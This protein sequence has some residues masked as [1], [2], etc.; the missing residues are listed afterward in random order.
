MAAAALL[1][2]LAATTPARA[3]DPG[4]EWYERGRLALAQGE[5]WRARGHFE[6]A[7]REGYPDNP[8]YR[9]LADAWM[10]LDHRLFEAREALE[11]AVRADPEDVDSWYR[12][13]DVNLKLDGGDADGRSRLAFHQVFR[14]DPF[15]RDAWERWG[16]LYLDPVDLTAVAETF[17]RH[18]ET[19]YDPRVA[20]RRIEVLHD[21]GEH[22]AA[23]SEIE[24]FRRIV[25]DEAHLS[26][27]S[28][29][30]GVV[31]AAREQPLEG[32][33]YYFNGL[34]FA[35]TPGDLDP[36]FED[37][38]PLLDP[39]A[40]GTWTEWDLERRRQFLRGWW[41]ARD[42]LPF[43]DLNER[44]AEQQRRIRV[45][46]DAFRWKKPI[47]KEKLVEQGGTDAGMPAVA[48]RLDGRPL[49][50]RGAFYLRH[51]DPDD[52]ADPG[53]D[54]CGFW[55]YDREEIP[56]DR[57]IA[58]NF[59]R[60]GA[61]LGNDCNFV[62]VPSTPKGLQHFSPGVGGLDPFQRA[63]VQEATTRDLAVGLS[64]DS[65]PVP[66]DDPIPLDVEPSNFSYFRDGTDVVIY[67]AVPLPEIEIEE[68]HSRYRK[69]LV[70]YD[71][72]WNEI[73]RS[74]EEMDAVLARVPTPAGEREEWYLVD[75]FRVRTAPGEYRFALQVDDLLGD[76]VGVRKGVLRVRRFAPT[77]LDLSDP[78][79]S[80]RVLEGGRAPRFER[81]GRT[82]IPLPG[83]RFV[84]GGPLWLYYEVY[85]LQPDSDRRLRFRIEYTIRADRLDRGAVERL[86]GALSGLV[87]IR[88]DRGATT[89]SFEREAPHPG[90]GV[91]PEDLSFD[92]S[93][94]PAGEYALDVTVI[95]H[96]FYDRRA[97]R[98]T[99]FTIVD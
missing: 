59:A 74:A 38:A 89:L 30:A 87:G 31:L 35:R 39:A 10:A 57:S 99:T 54:E 68:G 29:F 41:N 16:R 1:G 17:G 70:I 13:A 82:I 47:T 23:W 94:L 51:G 63:R 61:F 60:G 93:G 42:P 27:L 11:G 66:I 34:A 85:N 55:L 18:L 20:L 9:A 80:T 58:M 40:R 88:E 25:K 72:E 26:R 8:G 69:G 43:S 14:L 36:Y 6:R 95:D 83:K 81:Y 48:I 79:V 5:A 46:R 50:D 2:A 7:L 78:L 75:L 32:A 65:W 44:W 96:V 15:H 24:R 67:F 4:T 45:A 76:G 84:R 73:T 53:I 33:S 77:G 71:T 3:Q 98:S 52:R 64:T 49:D 86:F 90:R 12:L 19:A 91:W 21:A 92:T 28:Y 37:V 56:G 22:D 97:T 62:T